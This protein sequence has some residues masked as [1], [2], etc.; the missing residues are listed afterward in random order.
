M[1]SVTPSV[2][3]DG[4]NQAP[5]GFAEFVSLI[6]AMM[7]LTAL[8]IDSMLPALPAIS[9]TLGV[10][11]ANDRQFI[12]TAFMVGFACAMLVYGPLTDRFGR[13]PVLAVALVGYVVTN[14]LAAVSGSFELLLIARAASGAMVA[15]ARTVTIALVRDCYSGRAMA[16]VMSLA[17]IVFMAAPVLAP[18]FGQMVLL[19]ANWRWI[20]AGIALVTAVILLWFLVRMPETLPVAERRPL[21][22][23]LLVDGAG[24]VVRD[25][26]AVGYTLAATALQGGLFGF[27]G[28]IQQIVTDVFGVPHLLALVFA[29]VAGTMA[30]GSFLNSRIVLRYGTRLI[31]HSA[32][33][34]FILLAALHLVIGLSGWENLANF[35][36]V[37]ALMMAC[38]ALATSN[39]SSMAMENMGDIAGTAASLQGF[40]A[41]LGA[42]LIGAYVGQQYNGTTVPLY[43]GFT[44]M[45]VLA[46]IVVLV[47]EKG[48]LFRPAHEP[49]I[50][51]G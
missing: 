26:Y 28:S 45:G 24:R 11:H 17:F 35:I 33:V 21:R 49:A 48:R 5:I 22:L 39:F 30:V 23:S 46:L 18:T 4:A 43:I 37:Q 10:A 44:V 34:G 31:S 7:A 9:A 8:G 50:S 27:I 14:L 15:G 3:D 51:A 16:R 12:I 40:V 13:R 42:A 38:F 1:A 2:A 32:L 47:A 36:V 29:A 6:A 41:T 25:R 19:F 20:F